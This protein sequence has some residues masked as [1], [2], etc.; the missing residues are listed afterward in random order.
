MAKKKSTKTALVKPPELIEPY[1]DFEHTIRSQQFGHAGTE[2]LWKPVY[3]EVLKG[4]NSYEESALELFAWIYTNHGDAGISFDGLK[5]L[6]HLILGERQR[7]ATARYE[8]VYIFRKEGLA[9]TPPPRCRILHVGVAFENSRIEFVGSRALE[10]AIISQFPDWAPPSESGEQEAG[11]LDRQAEIL[12]KLLAQFI[13]PENVDVDDRVITGIV[14]DVLASANARFCYAK[15]GGD[16]G[17]P[18]TEMGTRIRNYWQQAANAQEY[19]T[20]LLGFGQSIAQN[21]IERRLNASLKSGSVDE[22][23]Y[24]R[25][26]YA[27][28]GV[29]ILSAVPQVRDS[30]FRRPFDFQGT[31]GTHV[32]D[33]AAGMPLEDADPDDHIMVVQIP[34]LASAETWG[35][36]LDLFILL[37]VI[38]LL[39]WADTSYT[40]DGVPVRASIVINISYGVFAGAKDGEGFLEA[41]IARLVKA[42][43]DQGAAT[44]VVLPTGNGFRALGQ[45]KVSVPSL[46]FRA[47]DWRLQ[48]QDQSVSFLEIWFSKLESAKVSIK[49]PDQS[50]NSVEIAAFATREGSPINSVTP[51]QAPPLLENGA[52]ADDLVVGKFYVRRFERTGKTRVVIA[53]APTQNH[54]KPEIAV[55][56]GKYVVTVKNTGSRTIETDW[57]VQRDDTPSNF[58]KFGRQSY[59]DHPDVDG[60]DPATGIRDLP[61]PIDGPIRRF[62]TLS[63][64]V[65]APSD[66][67]YVVG[68]AFDRDK[69][70]KAALYAGSAPTQGRTVPNL[71]APSDETRAARGIMASGTYSGSTGALSGTSAAAPIATRAIVEELRKDIQENQAGNGTKRHDSAAIIRALLYRDDTRAAGAV[72]QLG[73]FTLGLRAEA[74]RPDRRSYRS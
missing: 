29:R 16:N 44:A 53:L 30:S 66:H 42:R 39:D 19:Q 70:S 57:S 34:Q 8:R 21:E 67:V 63:N 12:K 58:P 37:G 22:R 1:E 41:E 72:N 56:P 17:T 52:P 36:R 43:N 13:H 26:L 73:H 69:L 61:V 51:F 7:K 40:V 35:G 3:V 59:L 28:L 27:D 5:S 32:A 64:Y 71:S 2:D 24:Y 48:P 18:I 31:H 65:N 49:G 45:A 38:R 4:P 54:D 10:A 14:D 62:G 50:E 23:A 25:D 68:G 6:L 46:E 9:Y 74:G 11:V 55:R 60:L 47:L 33:L 15:A 20:F